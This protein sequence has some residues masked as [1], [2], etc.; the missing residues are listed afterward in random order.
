VPPPNAPPSAEFAVDVASLRD[1]VA[2]QL[3]LLREL[4]TVFH[5]QYPTQIA[6]I[7]ETSASRDAEELR[8]AA[9]RLI[10]TLACFSATRA[11]TAARAVEHAAASGDVDTAIAGV[12][13]IEREVAL[14]ESELTALAARGFEGPR[15]EAGP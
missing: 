15:T 7:R 11:V 3:P 6:R 14:A 8:K 2:G 10:G 1:R 5:Q 4:L 9:H 13:A 12:A